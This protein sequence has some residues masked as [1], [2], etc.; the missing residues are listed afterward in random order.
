MIT[1][2]GLCARLSG[3]AIELGFVDSISPETIRQMLKKWPFGI[4][5]GVQ[6]NE[7][8]VHRHEESEC[9]VEEINR[10]HNTFRF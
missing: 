9:I 6:A 7:H 1:T 3:K 5:C 8:C 4:R 10:E 2:I